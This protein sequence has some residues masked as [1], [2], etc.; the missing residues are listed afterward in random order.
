[1]LSI[2][3]YV[4][5]LGTVPVVALLDLLERNFVFVFHT[6]NIFQVR[7]RTIRS[8]KTF[9]RMLLKPFKSRFIEAD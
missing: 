8:R 5:I 2:I 7:R 3:A 9:C 4:T 6:H 1:M